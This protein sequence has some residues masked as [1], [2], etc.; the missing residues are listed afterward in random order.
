MS[1]AGRGAPAEGGAEGGA[2][3]AAGQGELEKL[4]HQARTFGAHGDHRELLNSFLD[5]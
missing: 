2:A 5:Y 1:A 3:P 4:E